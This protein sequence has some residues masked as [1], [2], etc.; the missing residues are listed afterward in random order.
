[1]EK[2]QHR[3]AIDLRSIVD[4]LPKATGVELATGA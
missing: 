1:V 2:R 3:E 4:V